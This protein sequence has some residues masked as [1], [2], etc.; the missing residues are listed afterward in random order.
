MFLREQHPPQRFAF[1]V[2]KCYVVPVIRRA[3][4]SIRS[5]SARRVRLPPR[6]H[7]CPDFLPQPLQIGQRQHAFDLHVIRLRQVRPVFQHLRRPVPVICQK[8]HPRRRIIQTPHRLNP[9][10]HSTRTIPHL[11]PHPPLRLCCRDVR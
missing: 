3:P 7:P 11:L 1:R 10:F 2:L 9:P 5:E 6:P 8:H 4:A